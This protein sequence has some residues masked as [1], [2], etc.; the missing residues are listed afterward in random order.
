M[1][2]LSNTTD[3]VLPV[4]KVKVPQP[5]KAAEPAP[6][7]VNGVEI[8]IDAI[9]TEAQHHPADT[10]NKAFTEAARALVVQQLLLQEA[11]T[12]GLTPKPE[13]L[14]DGLRETDE[15]AVTR[16]LLEKEVTT[17][18]AQEADCIRYYEANTHRFTSDTLYEAR[19]IL[20]AAPLSDED[21]RK[22]A[23]QEAEAAIA[24]L[25]KNPMMFSALAFSKSACPSK[26]QGGNLGQL[27]K[28]STV[29][30]FETV[31]FALAEGQLAPTPVPTPFGYHVIQLDRIIEGKQLPYEMVKGRISAWLEASSWS[32]AVSQYLSILAAKADIRGIKLDAADGPLVQ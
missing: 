12:L 20:F 21:A 16:A 28:G 3:S 10:P 31:L 27:T 32:R 29:P 11:V 19:H 9:Q 8:T 15:D 25:V 26:E 30:E 24:E 5:P 7:S 2:N 23:K 14:G 22:I 17:P 13:K 6:I 1:T 18:S 4:G